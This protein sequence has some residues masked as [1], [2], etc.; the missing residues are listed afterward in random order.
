MFQGAFSTHIAQLVD[1]AIDAVDNA[2]VAWRAT[3]TLGNSVRIDG[4]EAY[5]ANN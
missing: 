5:T 1:L 3:T 4:K 2:V